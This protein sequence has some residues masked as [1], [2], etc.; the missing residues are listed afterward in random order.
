MSG[1]ASPEEPQA[2]QRQRTDDTQ[3]LGALGLMGEIALSPGIPGLKIQK[4]VYFQP[5]LLSHLP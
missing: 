2:G 3:R 4:Q 1:G 5:H